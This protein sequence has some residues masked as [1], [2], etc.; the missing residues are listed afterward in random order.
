MT[1]THHETLEQA[2]LGYLSGGDLA[3]ATRTTGMSP[4]RFALAAERYREAGRSTL[5]P[6]P[7]GWAQVDIEF[8][9]YTHAENTFHDELWPVLRTRRWW[10]VRKRPHW[11][12]RYLDAGYPDLPGDLRDALDTMTAS[13]T[14]RRWRRAVYEPETAAFGGPAGLKAVNDIHVADATGL[15]T[16]LGTNADGGVDGPS[17]SLASLMTLAHLMRAAGL[18]WAEQGDVW[19]RVEELRP[20]AP[21]TDP[22][23]V[24]LAGKARSA[25]STDLTAL[26]RDDTDF[27]CL[28]T[29]AGELHDTGRHLAAITAGGA[30]QTGLRTVLARTVLFCWNR[31]GFTTEQ[32]SVWALAARRA[33]LG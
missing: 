23:S 16:Y 19:A 13:G 28:S 25:L 22:V 26:V 11:R 32:Q 9:D 3:V 30:L 27:A 8:V 15:L 29:W 24:G 21:I 10:F 33:I 1:R 31:A 2:V 17:R 6:D 5:D 18:E 7:S 20:E 4:S 12:L 14:L